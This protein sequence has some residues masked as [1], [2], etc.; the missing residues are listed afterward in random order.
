[1]LK[2]RQ[3][4]QIFK[5]FLK[6]KFLLPYL[7]LAWKIHQNEYKQAKFIDPVVL[8]IT[9]EFWENSLKFQI[10]QPQI[11]N[12]LVSIKAQLTAIIHTYAFDD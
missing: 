6:F 1:M 3:Q 11:C 12:Q 10:F 7:D 5:L 2:Y 9:S 4:V 8:E